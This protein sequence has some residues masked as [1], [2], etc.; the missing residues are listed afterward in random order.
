MAPERGEPSRTVTFHGSLGTAHDDGNIGFAEVRQ[1]AQHDRL[2]LAAGQASEAVHEVHTL[3]DVGVDQTEG[4]VDGWR[5]TAAPT[6]AVDG[7]IGGDAG[8][9]TLR[10]VLKARPPKGRPGQSLL[11]HIFGVSPIPKHAKRH[12]IGQPIQTIKG[13]VKTIWSLVRDRTSD[14]VA[15]QII[16]IP[17]SH[18]ANRLDHV[19]AGHLPQSR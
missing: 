13:Q 3:T 9:P 1:V 5:R 15:A 4:T 2:S 19:T 18:Q 12:P 6:N 17:A 11:G 16:G 14:H 7:Q 8:D 10:T